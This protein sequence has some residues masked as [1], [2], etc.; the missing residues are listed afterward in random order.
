[1]KSLSLVA[2][3]IAI[4]AFSSHINAQSNDII[5]SE[6]KPSDKPIIIDIARNRLPKGDEAQ[7]A[8]TLNYANI[9]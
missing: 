9:F 5:F 7:P 2:L 1:M 4:A 6:L 8:L 3:G